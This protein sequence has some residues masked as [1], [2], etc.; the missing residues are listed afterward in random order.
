MAKDHC[1]QY[2]VFLVSVRVKFGLW[3]EMKLWEQS[4]A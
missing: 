4:Y 3:N 2:D 1:L